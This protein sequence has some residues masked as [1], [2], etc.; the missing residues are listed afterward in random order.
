MA[1]AEE[2]CNWLQMRLGLDEVEL[3]KMVLRLPAVLGYS[4]EDNIEPSLAKLQERLGLDEA[5]LKTMVLRLPA[6]VQGYSYEDNIEP[7]LAKLH[8]W[9]GL[10]EVELKKVVLRR[11]VGGGLELRGQPR[12]VAGEAAGAAG[13]G[14][15]RS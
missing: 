10:D 7:S 11:P 9:L 15:R 12:A 3:K 6:V 2:N 1:H 8:K 5:Q 4:Y 14:A 13:A